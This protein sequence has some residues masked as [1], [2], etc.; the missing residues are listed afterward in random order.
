MTTNTINI[1]DNTLD[2]LAELASENGMGGATWD[3]LFAMLIK[4][5]RE[6]LKQKLTRELVNECIREWKEGGDI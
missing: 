3:E 5:H 6:V 4:C 2:N 1:S